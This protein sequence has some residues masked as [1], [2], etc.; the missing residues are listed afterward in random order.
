MLR[1]AIVD[2]ENIFCSELEKMLISYSEKYVV[3]IDIEVFYSGEEFINYIKK[4]QAYFDLLFLDIELYKINGVEVGKIIREELNNNTLQIIYISSKSHYALQLFQNRPLDFIIKPIKKDILFKCIDKFI[5]LSEI[6]VQYFEY[7]KDRN[8][9]HISVKDILYFEKMLKKTIIH[10]AGEKI[11][12]YCKTTDILESSVSRYF[13]QIHRSFIVN[14][15]HIK[16]FKPNEL[17]VTN[18][19]IL[20]IGDKHKE[21]INAYLLTLNESAF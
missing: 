11:V 3:K 17:S 20:P 1:A 9:N 18:N 12:T 7:I 14:K 21:N 5:A 2:D 16:S 8:V 15:L 6:N 19:D 4:E 10:T 13:L